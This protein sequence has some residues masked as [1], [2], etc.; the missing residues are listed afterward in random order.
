MRKNNMSEDK[1]FEKKAIDIEAYIEITYIDM[2]LEDKH[3][4]ALIGYIN[5][6]LKEVAQAQ[7]YACV[8]AYIHATFK[9]N[10]SETGYISA[11]QNAQI[12]RV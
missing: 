2:P 8:D 1:Y 3:K 4:L 11:I 12:K 9:P 7:R 6:R 10:E 5:L